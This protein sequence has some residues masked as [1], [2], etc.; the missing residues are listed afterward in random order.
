MGWEQRT[1]KAARKQDLPGVR[2]FAGHRHLLF[3]SRNV[4][5]GE[6]VAILGLSVLSLAF[7]LRVGEAAAVTPQDLVG[8][9]RGGK[10]NPR[11]WYSRIKTGFRRKCGEQTP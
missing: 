11:L 9:G 4:K 10:G 1:A 7:L 3:M 8:V 2:H 6:D 5:S